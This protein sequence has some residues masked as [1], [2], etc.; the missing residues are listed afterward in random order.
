MSIQVK[1]GWWYKNRA[2]DLVHIVGCNGPT[3]W[4]F[5][6]DIGYTYRKDGTFEIDEGEES[7]HDLVEEMGQLVP[8]PR[9]R[10]PATIA[11]LLRHATRHS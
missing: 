10:H 3:E 6:D 1:D 4:P 9:Q 11:H 7:R 8:E 5:Q 2:G